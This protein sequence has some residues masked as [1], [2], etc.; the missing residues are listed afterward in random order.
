MTSADA[1]GSGVVAVLLDGISVATPWAM[2]P[3]MS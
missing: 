2:S 1:G 3:M